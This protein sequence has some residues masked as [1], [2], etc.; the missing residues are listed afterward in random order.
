MG[1]STEAV[2]ASRTDSG[3][4]WH[5]IDF[6]VLPLVALTD[7]LVFSR[8]LRV[9][10][11]TAVERIGIVGY[12]LAGVALLVLRWRAPVPVYAASLVLAVPPL[13]FTDFYVPFMVPLVALAAV[14]QLRP[15][16]ESLL[17]LAAGI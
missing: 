7:L 16:R 13:L 9:E 15:T 10:G 6:I 1:S 8:L 2:P 5:R 4:R 3:H 11:V 14:A 12:S 17:C